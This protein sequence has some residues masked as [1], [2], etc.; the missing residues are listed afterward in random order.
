M[1]RVLLIDN[2][3]SFTFNLVHYLNEQPGII[4]E[5]VRNDDPSI[6]Q[7][8]SHSDRILISP[9]PGVPATNGHIIRVVKQFSGVVP[10]LGV[11][12]G[13]QTIYEAF[14]GN[15]VNLRRVYHGVNSMVSIVE[16]DPMLDGLPNPFNAGRYHS[17]ICD[18]VTLPAELTITAWDEENE[19]MACRHKV[20]PTFGV[21]FHPESILTPEGKRIIANFTQ[22]DYQPRI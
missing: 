14:G 6:F 4:L 20:H 15:L 19:I 21:Q 8:V 22:L 3:D 5:V 10:I 9:G 17:W 16:E 12:L 7:K 18:P 1:N 13:L 11:C 2:Y